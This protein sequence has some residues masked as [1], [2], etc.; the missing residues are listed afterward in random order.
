[1]AAKIDAGEVSRGEVFAI[2]PEHIIVSHDNNGS[3]WLEHS[4]EDVSDLVQSYETEGQ[5]QPVQVRKV[6]DNKVQ[7]VFGF[8][9]WHAATEYNKKH[10]DKPMKL[11]CIV[12]NCNAE[13]AL[14]RNIEENRNRKETSQVDDAYAARRLMEEF[15]W[16][17]S[18]VAEFFRTDPGYIGNILNL[19]KLPR[20]TQLQ[21]HNKQLSYEAA[22]GVAKLPEAEQKP[23][24][25]EISKE[26]T[27]SGGG[28]VKTSKVK[29]K[30]RAVVQ[31]KGGKVARTMK[32]LMEG[33]T[34]LT[35]P[36]EA[37]LLRDV[38]NEFIKFREGKTSEKTFEKNM[39]KL[40]GEPVATESA[41]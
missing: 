19:L 26:I 29:E 14:K 22:L 10:P 23:I 41:A 35:G 27:E 25:A 36:A 21:V 5:L 20:E 18:R 32:E 40:L 30:V 34:A 8:R 12:T 4:A 37:K 9:R 38:C 17:Q 7:L 16:N 6:E 11:K 3:R 31:E 39:R 28:K 13:E 1:M 15:Q 24:L 2:F 33:V